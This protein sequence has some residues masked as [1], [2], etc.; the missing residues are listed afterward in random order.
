MTCNRNRE[1]T[2]DVRHLCK[3]SA[4]QFVLVRRESYIDTIAHKGGNL[5]ER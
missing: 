1:R 4:H 2:S 5:Y 3:P